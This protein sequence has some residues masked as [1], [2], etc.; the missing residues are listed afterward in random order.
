MEAP[1]VAQVD[2]GK[3]DVGEFSPAKTESTSVNPVANTV[4]QP[5]AS[6]EAKVEAQPAV[7]VSP[8]KAPSPKP[9]SENLTTQKNDVQPMETEAPTPSKDVISKEEKAPAVENGVEDKAS[10]AAV[11]AVPAEGD[12]TSKSQPDKDKLQQ[13]SLSVILCSSK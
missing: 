4:D 5:V 8:A 1:A 10:V 12:G 7:A 11:D 9:V 2:A 6:T 3:K 13:V